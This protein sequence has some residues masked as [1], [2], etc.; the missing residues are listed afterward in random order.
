MNVL[1]YTDDS[2]QY[3][4]YNGS[5]VNKNNSKCYKLFIIKKKC[6]KYCKSKLRY[7]INKWFMI[8]CVMQL[9]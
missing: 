6:Y 4:Y 9:T 2:Q 8:N 1:Q 3:I 5:R 7:I